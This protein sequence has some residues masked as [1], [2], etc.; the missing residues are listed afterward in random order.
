MKTNAAIIANLFISATCARCSSTNQAKRGAPPDCGWLAGRTKGNEPLLG[1][2]RDR[3]RRQSDYASRLSVV[4]DAESRCRPIAMSSVT[5][6]AALVKSLGRPMG[7][8]G[9]DIGH[10]PGGAGMRKNDK[11]GEAPPASRDPIKKLGASDELFSRCRQ[12]AT[13]AA[14]YR[15]GPSCILLCS[16]TG[17]GIF[18]LRGLRRAHTDALSDVAV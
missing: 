16:A 6:K 17:V 1:L 11:H 18:E 9:C 12:P 5:K 2:F 7:S 10:R 15:P 3:F 14:Y 8:L 13:L 4:P